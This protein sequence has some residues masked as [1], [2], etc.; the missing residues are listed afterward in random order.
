[1]P[2]AT[3]E[4]MR[5]AP[6]PI[7]ISGWVRDTPDFRDR[8]FSTAVPVLQLL[9]P[10]VDLRGPLMPDVYDQQQIGSCTANAIG[11][12]IQ[13]VRRKWLY[14][15]DFLPSRLFLYYEARALEGTLAI[16]NG[17]QL[18][19]V[20]KVAA[21]T[22]VCREEIW[23][24]D[25]IPAPRDTHLFPTASRA[26][27]PP[28]QNCFDEAADHQAIAYWRVPQSLQQ[29]RGCLAEGFP[30]VFGFT[31]YESL[32]GADG[33]PLTEVPLPSADEKFVGAHA[34]CAVGYDDAAQCFTIR[35]SWGPQFHDGGYFRL[36][37]A[38]VT[39]PSLAADFW[40][41]RQLEA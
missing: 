6:P 4:P 37:Y 39:D 3:I 13:F 22:G 18:R 19:T 30:F 24:Y 40:T 21:K 14:A 28:G 36:P 15:N 10:S 26:V 41:I 35:N 27:A 9:P 25:A 12:M 31:I 34:V 7:R 23:P 17:A 33:W 5:G 29:L 8:T 20:V 16:D 11:A 32:Y 38:Y 1:M 2:E